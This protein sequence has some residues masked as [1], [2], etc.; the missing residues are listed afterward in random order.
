M[1]SN[2]YLLKSVQ[3]I[4]FFMLLFFFFFFLFMPSGMSLVIAAVVS[5]AHFTV[6]W[7]IPCPVPVWN[8][9]LTTGAVLQDF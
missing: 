6:V 9:A 8:P 7:V 3:L 4:F 2:L 1:A 5:R